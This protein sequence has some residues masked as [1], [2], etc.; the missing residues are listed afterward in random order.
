MKCGELLTQNKSDENFCK[1]FQRI[2]RAFEVDLPTIVRQKTM[3]FGGLIQI[4]VPL[5]IL[6]VKGLMHWRTA[7]EQITNRSKQDLQFTCLAN[8]K[9]WKGRRKAGNH[10]HRNRSFLVIVALAI[11][12]FPVYLS[13]KAIISARTSWAGPAAWPSGGLTVKECRAN[14]QTINCKHVQWK[15]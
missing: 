5:F 8:T 7:N 4:F 9:D 12:F 6:L 11:S 1:G 3:W 2:L 14:S 13:R 10:C 15:P